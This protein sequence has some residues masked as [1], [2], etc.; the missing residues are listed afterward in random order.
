MSEPEHISNV[1]E[2]VLKQIEVKYV[3]R[4]RKAVN[5]SNVPNTQSKASLV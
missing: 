4:R 1:V 5:K 2:R 3:Q